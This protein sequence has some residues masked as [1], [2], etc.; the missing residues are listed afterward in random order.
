[1]VSIGGF[2]GFD[3]RGISLEGRLNTALLA[4]RS[5]WHRKPSVLNSSQSHPRASSGCRDHDKFRVHLV[6]VVGESLR[7]PEVVAKATQ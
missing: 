6:V 2:V 3:A 1:M 5:K 4:K 7:R